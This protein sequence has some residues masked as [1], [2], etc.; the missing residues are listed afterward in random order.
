MLCLSEV[1]GLLIMNDGLFSL[2]YI[3]YMGLNVCG[4]NEH[5]TCWL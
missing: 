3:I 2:K 4:G 1:Y 5:M